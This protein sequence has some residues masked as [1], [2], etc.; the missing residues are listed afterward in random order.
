[1]P[2]TS[3]PAAQRTEAEHPDPS[4]LLIVYYI[5]SA[6]NDTQHRKSSPMTQAA[7]P[8]AKELVIIFRAYSYS[9]EKLSFIK[10]AVL[11]EMPN[12]EIHVPRLGTSIYS[13][14]DPNRMLL[15]VLQWMDDR[16]AESITT[17]AGYKKIVLIGHGFGAL[18]ARKLYICACGEN[19]DAPFEP[20]LSAACQAPRP[21]AAKVERLVLFAA[22]SR[23]WSI[24]HHMTYRNYVRFV[25]GEILGNLFY[26]FTGKQLLLFQIKRG[27]EFITQLRILWLFMAKH[28]PQKGVGNALTVQLLGTIDDMIAPDDNIDMVAGKNFVYLD[29]PGSGHVNV[30]ELD[31]S[32]AGK[33]RRK[34][35]KDALS[36]SPDELARK[37]VSTLTT[38]HQQPD[39]SVDDVIF[40]VHG[41]R[42]KGYWTQR[43]GRKIS[44]INNASAKPRNIRIETSSYGYFAMLPFLFYKKRREKVEWL[45]DR[46]TENLSLYPNAEF[47]YFGH[48]NGTYLLAKALQDYPACKFKHV[49]LAGSVISNSYD[50]QSLIAS[51]RVQVV[52]NIVATKDWVVALFP[53][54]FQIVK[55]QDLGS[56][57]H[58]GFA[59]GTSD[60]F[61]QYKYVIGEHDAAL[62]EE[63]WEAIADF[64]LNGKS[65][66]PPVSIISKQQSSYLKR[67][68]LLSVFVWG[69]IL[70]LILGPALY[71][72]FYKVNGWNHLNESSLLTNLHTYLTNTRLAVLLYFVFLWIIWKLTNKF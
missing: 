24:S 4:F 30:I 22:M 29:V 61:E 48:S 49:A 56:A 34:I 6:L 31:A 58:D 27:A 37:S 15:E 67:S 21:W 38:M 17:G 36:L 1:V 11:Q 19:P 70:L 65:K 10:E 5:L 46:Y 50:W 71:F 69:I 52:R 62:V 8:E 12:A 59:T 45:M 14:E 60:H 26:L 40:I 35:F 33:V 66:E 23:G 55:L 13:M 3:T 72:L 63:N 2:R 41:I 43:I 18:L 9:D 47:S 64:M 42:D 53:K 51:G 68:T 44:E 16:Y 39:P 25:V 57:G 32:A 54:F 7:S 28:A 20:E